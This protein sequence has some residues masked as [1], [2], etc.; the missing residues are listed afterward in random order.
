V[1][2]D[3]GGQVEQSPH[4]SVAVQSKSDWSV[5]NKTGRVIHTLE[6]LK[7]ANAYRLQGEGI[8]PISL[9]ISVARR[10]IWPNGWSMAVE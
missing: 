5:T 4:L 6:L 2:D 9:L 8:S 10:S 7:S 1:L 3:I